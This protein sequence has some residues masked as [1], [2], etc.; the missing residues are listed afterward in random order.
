MLNRIKAAAKA[1]RTPYDEP[2]PEQEQ[3]WQSAMADQVKR[4][5]QNLTILSKTL[6][7]DTRYTQLRMMYERILEQTTR[8][9]IWYNVPSGFTGDRA[10]LYLEQ[11]RHFQEQLRVLSQIVELPKEFAARAHVEPAPSN[12]AEAFNGTR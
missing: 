12:P 2:S 8:A 3:D 4:E 1:F 10:Q 11:M 5:A 7:Q 9:L 6:L